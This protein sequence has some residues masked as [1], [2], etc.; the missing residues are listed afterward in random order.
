MTAE[1]DKKVE[2][3][4]TELQRELERE[5][6]EVLAARREAEGAV[7]ASREETNRHQARLAAVCR[8]EGRL[9][10]KMADAER[11]AVVRSKLAKLKQARQR[12]ALLHREEPQ[13]SA[14]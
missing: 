13:E 3:V 7:A 8:R 10:L 5:L 6:E 11:A 9:R 14:V 1:P 12:E 4:L 2:R